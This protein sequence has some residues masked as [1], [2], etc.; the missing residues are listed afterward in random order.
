M[1]TFADLWRSTIF[2]KWVMAISGL[3]WVGF[4][5]GHLAANLLVYV[6]PDALNA[7]GADLRALG[8]GTAI[9]GA[10]LALLA[11]FVL[12]MFTAFRLVRLNKTARPGN[13]AQSDYRA[14]SVASRTMAYSG[15]LLLL[16]VLYHLAHFTWGAVHAE[17]Y[18]GQYTLPDGRIV[19]D[20]NKMLINSFQQPLI[21]VLYIVATVGLG[22][23]LNHAISSAVQ[24]L[25]I[26][27]PKYVGLIRK[28]G[29]GLSVAIAGGF[30]S[31]PVAVLSG[32][33]Q[34]P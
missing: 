30:V 11:F 34:L 3:I 9:W 23:H 22:F 12:H 17:F 16:Y 29:I 21:A 15:V 6:G 7:Y 19:H 26:N 10:R 4:L 13:Y 1:R 33:V 32:L 14:S 28:A 31:I 25:G 5:I 20:V 27:H 2:S 24:T 18:Q 8:H